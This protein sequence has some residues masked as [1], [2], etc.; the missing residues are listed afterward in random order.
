MAEGDLKHLCDT[1]VVALEKEGKSFVVP[2]RK[3]ELPTELEG[4]ESGNKIAEA[5]GRIGNAKQ[6]GQ[7]VS[8]ESMKETTQQ[9]MNVVLVPTATI[10]GR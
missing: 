7:D 6:S 8:Y 5:M 10:I 4:A 9:R 2:W 3:E 1:L